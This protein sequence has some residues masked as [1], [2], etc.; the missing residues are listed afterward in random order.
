MSLTFLT[1]AL[2]Y[3]AGI[4]QNYAIELTS[5]VIYDKLTEK[6][7]E[8]LIASCL[9][10]AV[11][12]KSELLNRCASSARLGDSVPEAYVD[13]A[14]LSEYLRQNSVVEPLLT[15][16]GSASPWRPY[17]S[18][19]ADIIYIPG[20]DLSESVRLDLVQGVLEEASKI[21]NA[22]LPHAQPALDQVMLE[23]HKSHRADPAQPAISKRPA[24]HLACPATA[25][26]SN[27][28][29]C[30]FLIMCAASIPSSVQSAV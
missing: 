1:V 15:E 30:S 27:L 26:L 25:L 28:F 20:F 14:K 7:L 8:S 5:A 21:F 16:V 9:K 6:E 4:T 17:L 3:L 24:A 29:T 22:R 19:F 23:Y 18:P 12:N 10:E 2:G 13:E 11:E